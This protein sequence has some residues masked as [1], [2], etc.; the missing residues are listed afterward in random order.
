[1]SAS[2]HAFV[3]KTA[4]ESLDK[5]CSRPFQETSRGFQPREPHTTTC[6][7]EEQVFLF[8]R[9][10]INSSLRDFNLKAEFHIWTHIARSIL[11][12]VVCA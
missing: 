8:S 9:Y 2:G 3:P 4:E 6:G 11:Y 10:S 5:A 7:S 12:I 1:M